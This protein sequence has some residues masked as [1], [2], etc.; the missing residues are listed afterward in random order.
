[1][2][3]ILAFDIGTADRGSGVVAFETT[4]TPRDPVCWAN[5]KILSPSMEKNSII[6]KSQSIMLPAAWWTQH[7]PNEVEIVFEGISSYGNTAGKSIYRTLLWIGRLWQ[8]F[9]LYEPKM[10]LRAT[11]KSH[12]CGPRAKDGDVIQAIRDRFGGVGAVD[13]DV[14]GTKANPGP[15]YGFK[16]DIWQAMGLGIAYVEGARQE[17]PFGGES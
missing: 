10:V 13:K 14:K 1:M 12:L 7:A 8:C 16:A 9:D 2:R 17:F 3:R 15:L 4:A 6:V 11:A 5:T